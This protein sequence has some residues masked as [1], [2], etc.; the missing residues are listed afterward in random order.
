MV[1][2]IGVFVAALMPAVWL[3][4]RSAARF[5]FDADKWLHLFSFLVLALWFSGQYARRSYWRIAV[6]LLIFG[7]IIELCQRA[8]IYR[9]ADL[10][11]LAADAAGISLGLGIAWLGVGG[12]S[13][14]FEDWIVHR[15]QKA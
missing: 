2:L 14:K 9:T 3:S 10:R 1:V 6:G 13:L 8:L 15:R 4:P 11:D 12:W 7:I 5:L